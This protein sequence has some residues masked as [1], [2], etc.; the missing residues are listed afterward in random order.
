MNDPAQEFAERVAA[1][2]FGPE[3]RRYVEGLVTIIAT[4]LRTEGWRPPE[5]ET[6]RETR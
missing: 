4:E 1:M 3:W 2:W 6:V 5:Y